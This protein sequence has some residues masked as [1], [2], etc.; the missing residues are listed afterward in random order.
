MYTNLDLHKSR[1]TQILT[2]TNGESQLTQM[3]NLN[4]HKTN[5]TC[6]NNYRTQTEHQWPVDADT[7]I[8]TGCAQNTNSD[9]PIT[10]GANSLCSAAAMATAFTTE[11]VVVEAQSELD[12]D[13]AGSYGVVH[14]AGSAGGGAGCSST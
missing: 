9:L 11:V 8:H 5:V 10:R 3:V 6:T 14:T 1:L 7:V 13:P 4:S 12:D 2:Y